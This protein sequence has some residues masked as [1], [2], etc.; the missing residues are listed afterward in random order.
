[1]SGGMA[2]LGRD[3]RQAVEV[4]VEQWNERGGLLGRRIHLVVEDDRDDPTEA[5]AVATRLVRAG[6]WGVIGHLTSS[7]SLPASRI[8]HAAEVPQI[9]PSSTDPRLTEQRFRNLFRTCGRDDRQGEIAA[10][11]VIEAL[12]PRRV[13]VVHDTTRY[14]EALAASFRRRVGRTG[15]RQIVGTFPLSSGTRNLASV[16]EQVKALAPD[17]VYFGGIFREGGLLLRR[18]R[19]QGVTAAFVSGDGVIGAEFVSLA[20]EAAATG[21]YLTFAPN[22][23]TLPSAQ[24]AIRRF[25]QRYGAIGPYTLYAYDAAGALL[26]AIATAKPRAPSRAQL[27]R[28]S[29]SL[30]NMTYAGALGKLRW[31]RNGD[32]IDQPYVVY[33]ARKGGD[34]QGWFEQVTGRRQRL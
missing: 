28:V 2:E 7:A 23:M 24:S 18:L 19:E 1:M 15:R 10:E 12:D 3:V 22:P 30:H 16:A 31:D 25:Q 13:V 9:T 33:R 14:G 6:V 26:T 11:F 17:V 32:L 29:E 34:F 27:R 5:V 8:Y 4:Q 20:G 21:A